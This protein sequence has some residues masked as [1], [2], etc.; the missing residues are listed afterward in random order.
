MTLPRSVLDGPTDGPVE[1]ALR[2]L[3]IIGGGAGFL[4][5]FV[6]VSVL[7]GLLKKKA[8]QAVALTRTP[9]GSDAQR[10]AQVHV[11]ASTTPDESMYD[12]G[13]IKRRRWFGR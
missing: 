7:V 5:A 1:L 6:V 11:T 10:S 8:R 13:E 12:T 4:V 3:V 9:A 2:A